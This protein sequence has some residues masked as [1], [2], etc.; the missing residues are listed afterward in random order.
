MNHTKPDGPLPC[1]RLRFLVLVL[2]ATCLL[3]LLVAPLVVA[4]AVLIREPLV[5]GVPV[6]GVA[7][8]FVASAGYLASSSNQWVEL[9]GGIIRCRRLLTRKIVEHKVSDIVDAQPI[10]TNYL[11]AKE[12]AFLDDLFETSNRGYQLFF[13]DGTKLALIRLD[14]SGLNE[15]LAALAEQMPRDRQETNPS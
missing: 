11:S 4:V 2:A 13:R 3:V 5:I 7:V 9:D 14:M 8:V 10:H 12:N 6:A 1:A 15:F